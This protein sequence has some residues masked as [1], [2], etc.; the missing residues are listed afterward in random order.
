MRCCSVKHGCCSLIACCC[1]Q[2]SDVVRVG[3]AS[4]LQDVENVSAG[5]KCLAQLVALPARSSHAV[6]LADR[7]CFGVVVEGRAAFCVPTIFTS[8]YVGIRQHTSAY[9]SIRQ[10]KHTL[11]PACAPS[12][13]QHTSAYVS[14]RQHTSAYVSIGTRCF[15][16][17]HHLSLTLGLCSAEAV[18]LAPL[19][20]PR[21]LPGL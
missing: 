4:T 21:H 10:H 5:P 1:T 3:G 14:I 16:R 19:A 18:A 7:R 9:V 6:V 11:L 15:L 2:F 8:A 13:R 20:Q 17:A 12:L